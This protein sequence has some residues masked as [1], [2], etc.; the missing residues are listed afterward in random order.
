MSPKNLYRLTCFLSLVNIAFIGY[1]SWEYEFG[2]GH[3]LHPGFFFVTLFSTFFF[4]RFPLLGQG[5]PESE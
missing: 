4:L 5:G 2:S 1:L 3:G